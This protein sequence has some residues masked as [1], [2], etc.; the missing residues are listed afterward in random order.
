MKQAVTLIVVV[1][2]L[3]GCS[4]L[5]R[6]HGSHE[7]GSDP[8][9]ESFSSN[10][11]TAREDP[12]QSSKFEALIAAL[13]KGGDVHSHLSGAVSVAELLRIV[14]L[15]GY[16]LV[17]SQVGTEFCGFAYGNIDHRGFNPA[18]APRHC[19]S[20]P[21]T[22]RTVADLRG[23]DAALRNS[24][25][26]VLTVEHRENDSEQ[27]G[28]RQFNRV[29]DSVHKLTDNPDNMGELV[30]STMQ[31][32][33]ANRVSYLELMLN[34][35]GRDR[36][37]N[38]NGQWREVTVSI[39]ETLDIIAKAIDRTNT[40]LRAKWHSDGRFLPPGTPQGAW[41]TVWP[42]PVEVRIIIAGRRIRFARPGSVAGTG[43][44]NLAIP[45]IE[46]SP[47]CPSRLEQGYYLA[48][49]AYRN[50]VVGID[51]VG[52]P[53]EDYRQ[54]NPPVTQVVSIEEA[55]AGL[56][57]KYG[58]APLKLHA[59]ETHLAARSH[60]IAQVVAL[61]ARRIGHGY[62]LTSDAAAQDAVCRHRVPLEIALTSNYSLNLVG[63]IASHPFPE[64][65]RG[66][67]CGTDHVLYPVM[68]STDDAGIFQTNM[69]SEFLKAVR[70]F[71][72][73]WV[74]TKQLA[75]NSLLYSFSN[76]NDKAA[77]INRWHQEVEA[78]EATWT[79]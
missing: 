8:G 17:F 25:R 40:A 31:E 38:V 21:F 47:E 22:Y 51:L 60:H 24:V 33:Y 66:S 42:Q 18:V 79:W 54:D 50:L 75:L 12:S 56:R 29:F 63:S 28:F 67:M 30:A 2:S 76:R 73:T 11:E 70:T 32:A 61:G 20:P 27:S 74:E 34:P 1:L 58:D 53:E 15:K 46:C 36:V 78:L 68:L 23:A 55:L 44:A 59:G 65:F 72:L 57:L 6:R 4:T 69:N 16:R 19:Q 7:L 14:G 35:I 5:E 10:F 77:L 9:I 26:D 45:A 3:C 52:L 43:Q 41:P 48:S 13:P 49:Q 71:D 37:V 62:A 39:A 64:F